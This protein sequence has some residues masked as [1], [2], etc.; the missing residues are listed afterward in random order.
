MNDQLSLLGRVGVHNARARDTFTATG[1]VVVT[2]PN[3][4]IKETNYKAGVGFSYK[5]SQ[6]MTLRGELER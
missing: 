4:E 2:N 6:S 3:P 5:F 1:A